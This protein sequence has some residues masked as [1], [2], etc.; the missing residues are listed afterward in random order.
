MKR[1]ALVA[2]ALGILSAPAVAAGLKVK[3][4]VLKAP[5]PPAFSWAG[6]YI[7]G[8]GGG[9]WSNDD[10]S[11]SALGPQPT[12]AAVAGAIPTSFS[13]N[14]ASWIAGGQL[15]YNSQIQSVVFGIEGDFSATNLNGS[16]T[17]S[18]AVPTFFALTQTVSSKMDE[19]ATVRGRIGIAHDNWLFYTTAGVATGHV[20]Y[21]FFQSNVAGGGPVLINNNNERWQSGAVAGGGVEVGWGQVSLKAEALWFDLLDFTQSAPL[22]LVGGVTVPGNTLLATHQN[23]G[24]IARMGL[25]YRFGAW[26]NAR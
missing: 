19:F 7:G 21:G 12:P 4:P 11:V 5:P 13:Y 17:I 24:A 22:T 25:N 14:R 15:G 6:W 26:P 18:T 10:P 20:K 9:I 23:R 16:Q 2:A 3:A 8:H 1:L